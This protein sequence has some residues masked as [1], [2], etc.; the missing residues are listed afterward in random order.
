MQRVQCLFCRH[1]NLET[2]TCPAFPEGIPVEILSG[3]VQHLNPLAGQRGQWV[4]EALSTEA[5]D[6]KARYFIKKAEG[7][8]RAKK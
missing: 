3:E 5:F 2:A 6:R 7:G 1:F 4:F 8:R